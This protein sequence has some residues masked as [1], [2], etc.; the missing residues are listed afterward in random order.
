[1]DVDDWL[2]ESDESDSNSDTEKEEEVSET[3]AEEIVRWSTI[4]LTEETKDITGEFAAAA[5]R[6]PADLVARCME[7]ASRRQKI[8]VL[9]PLPVKEF[10]KLDATCANIRSEAHHSGG[11]HLDKEV[12]EVEGPQ[13]HAQEHS[14]EAQSEKAIE[15][16]ESDEDEME[17][18]YKKA[19]LAKAK[20]ADLLRNKHNQNCPPAQ[21]IRFSP[22]FRRDLELSGSSR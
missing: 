8:Q 15:G 12:V 16:L 2:S 1:M 6:N 14:T 13:E 18:L 4:A 17:N 22:S 9:R 20:P 19:S 21:C 7:N 10:K 5:S 3:P 11:K